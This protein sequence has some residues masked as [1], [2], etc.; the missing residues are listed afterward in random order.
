M[1]GGGASI[2][3]TCLDVLVQ[4]VNEGI[5]LLTVLWLQLQSV[6]GMDPLAEGAGGPRQQRLESRRPS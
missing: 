5:Q 1:W 4:L 6:T 2:S 3:P